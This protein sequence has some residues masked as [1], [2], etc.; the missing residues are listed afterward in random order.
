[1]RERCIWSRRS[2]RQ[3]GS[4]LGSGTPSYSGWF[5]R[6]RVVGQRPSWM[7]STKR[8][9][10]RVCSARAV[11]ER[12]LNGSVDQPCERAGRRKRRRI[13]NYS[14]SCLQSQAMVS[15]QNPRDAV[16][17]KSKKISHKSYTFAINTVCFLSIMFSEKLCISTIMK[18]SKI[19]LK[20]Y[21]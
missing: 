11:L 10:A 20:I 21:I 9:P 3:A 1:M 5:P 7:D 6:D 12:K 14:T 8:A 13:N 17:K 18:K 15:D 4:A 16:G 2:R 19:D